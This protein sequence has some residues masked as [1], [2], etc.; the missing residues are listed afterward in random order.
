MAKTTQLPAEVAQHYELVN[1]KG[2]SKQF[3]GKYGTIDISQL[4]LKKADALHQRGWPK[5]KKKQPAQPQTKTEE[6]NK[7]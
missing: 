6:K 5:L 7:K 4:T 2:S 1:Y 3:W